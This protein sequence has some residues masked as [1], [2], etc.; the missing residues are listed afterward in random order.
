MRFICVDCGFEV[1]YDE[2]EEEIIGCDECDGI[3]HSNP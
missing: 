3:M 1:D 2:S